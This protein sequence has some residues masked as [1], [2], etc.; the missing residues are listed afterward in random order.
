MKV[1]IAWSEE[2]FSYSSMVFATKE[3]GIK[4]YGEQAIKHMGIHFEQV[5]VIS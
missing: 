2:N 4:H 5:K 1:W 3:A